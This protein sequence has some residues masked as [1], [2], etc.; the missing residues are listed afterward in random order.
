M[1]ADDGDAMTGLA[2]HRVLPQRLGIASID[3]LRTGQYRKPGGAPLQ[4]PVCEHSIQ[5]RE[6]GPLIGPLKRDWHPATIVFHSAFDDVPFK[7]SSRSGLS[8]LEYS[9]R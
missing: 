2:H 1:I 9:V 8:R 4:V 5:R 3:A 7:R 6:D